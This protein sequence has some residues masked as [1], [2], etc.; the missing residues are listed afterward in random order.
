MVSE[1]NMELLRGYDDL[2]GLDHRFANLIS[3]FLKFPLPWR[4]RVGVRGQMD[5]TMIKAR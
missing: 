2:K 3:P 4:E 5:E 1:E